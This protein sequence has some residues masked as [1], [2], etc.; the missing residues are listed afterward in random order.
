MR[1][2]TGS[3]SNVA[4]AKALLREISNMGRKTKDVF[5]RS[6]SQCGARIVKK[7]W[8]LPSGTN[9]TWRNEAHQ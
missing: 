9:G 4:F 2:S 7:L 6:H 8:R 3:A 5:E 1:L